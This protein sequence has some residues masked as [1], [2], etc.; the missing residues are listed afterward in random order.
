M[1]R[2]RYRAATSLDGYIAGP[3]GEVDWIVG[4]PEIDF[5]AIYA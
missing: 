4:H 3:N 1:R 5:R 2:V